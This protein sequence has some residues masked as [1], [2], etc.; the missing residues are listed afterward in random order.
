MTNT[1]LCAQNDV[2]ARLEDFLYALLGDVDLA[3]ANGLQLLWVINKYLTAPCVNAIHE[4][5]MIKVTYVDAQL[6]ARLHQVEVNAGNLGIDNTLGHG[7]RSHTA[8]ECISVNQPALLGRAPVRLQHVDAVDRV[9][10]LALLVGALDRSHG[11]HNHIG[12]DL[13]LW[14]VSIWCVTRNDPWDGT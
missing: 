5:E 3:L 7:L 6:H 4:T 10:G 12:K 2:G 14:F 11:I 8:V 13:R 1:H 9:L